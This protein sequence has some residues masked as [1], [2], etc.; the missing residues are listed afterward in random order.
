M[1]WEASV[2]VDAV[3]AVAAAGRLSN[4]RVW[5]RDVMPDW[6]ILSYRRKSSLLSG[7]NPKETLYGRAAC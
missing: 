5:S 1:K 6:A 3:G 4:V 2:R 7:L